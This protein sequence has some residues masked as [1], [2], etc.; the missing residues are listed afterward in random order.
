MLVAFCATAQKAE[1]VSE[2]QKIRA[3]YTGSELK[4]V[5]GQMLLKN[6]GTAKPIDK[7]DFEYWVKDKEIFTRMNY[8]EILNN[9][10]VYIMV[11][12]KKKSIYA[13]QQAD[14]I[15]KTSV[16]FFDPEQLNVLL[17]SKASSITVTKGGAINKITMSGLQNT[18]F[19]SITISYSAT[20]Y[21]ITAIDATVSDTPGSAQRSV[22]EIRYNTTEKTTVSAEPAVFSSTKYLVETSKGKFNYTN[23]Y[24]NYQKL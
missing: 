22:L 13:R 15:Q 21:K 8:I 16:G 14:V 12:N 3:Y 18:R 4:H 19:S 6:A 20:D 10:D 2:L 1:A 7:V 5:A 23:N 17:S 24:I 9:N 11:N